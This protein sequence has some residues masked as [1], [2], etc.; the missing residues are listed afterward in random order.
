MKMKEIRMAA[1]SEQMATANGKGREW[2][3]NTAMELMHL[4]DEGLRGLPM[5][6]L[7]ND[8]RQPAH[9]ISFDSEFGKDARSTRFDEYYG[10]HTSVLGSSSPRRRS[11]VPAIISHPPSKDTRAVALLPRNAEPPRPTAHHV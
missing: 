11:A 9:G 5:S 8:T 3:A 2:A 4:E 6:M 7:I 1:L 10:S